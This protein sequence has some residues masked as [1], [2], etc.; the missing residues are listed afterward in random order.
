MRRLS[1]VEIRRRVQQ[2]LTTMAKKSAPNATSSEPKFPYT[3]AP[4]SL[5]KF[6]KQVPDKPKPPKVTNEL[7]KGWGLTSSNDRYIIGILKKLD[8]LDA[9][10]TPTQNYESFMFKGTGPATMG[11][12][13]RRVYGPLFQA[14]HRPHEDGQED[15]KRLFHIHSGGSEGTINLQ[16]Q[17]FKALCE[18]ASFEP[19]LA[20]SQLVANGQATHAAAGAA[21]IPATVGG[22]IPTIHIDLHIHLPENKTTRDYEAIIQDIARYIY[23][24]EVGNNGH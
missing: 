3:P 21:P 6:L 12:Q 20:A 8:F 23:K 11:A 5:R 4:N 16:I 18:F 15:L 9:S 22:G 24:Q 19:Q 2:G 7:L 14:S 17:T 10:G 1:R 13:L